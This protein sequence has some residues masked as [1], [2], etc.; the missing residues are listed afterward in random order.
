MKKAHVPRSDLNPRAHHPFTL[1]RSVPTLEL[2][3]KLLFLSEELKNLVSVAKD[4]NTVS[5]IGK[6]SNLSPSVVYKLAETVSLDGPRI[7]IVW[8]YRIFL[9]FPIVHS[10]IKIVIFDMKQRRSSSRNAYPGMLEFV[11]SR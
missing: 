9:H 1:D 2:F 11:L 10:F 6:L 7:L 8:L 5:K 3:L 4:R